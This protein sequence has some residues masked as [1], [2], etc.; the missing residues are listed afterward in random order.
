MLV[1]I[2]HYLVQAAGASYWSVIKG[3]ECRPTVITEV[4]REYYSRVN[5]VIDD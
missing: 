3:H 2:L 4:T 5:F 1:C